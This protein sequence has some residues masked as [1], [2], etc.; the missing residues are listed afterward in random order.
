METSALIDG[1]LRGDVRSVARAISAAENGSPRA[2]EVLAS[3]YPKTGRAL[4]V[5]LTG[6]PGAGKSTPA[7]R[8]ALHYRGEGHR[9]GVVAVDPSSPFSG[10]AILGDR[11]RMKALA[12][13]P[14]VFIR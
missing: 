10:G 5:G 6:S 7:H 4:V 1:V 3:V 9:V 13:D 14:G 11:I 12:T 2:A 8:L